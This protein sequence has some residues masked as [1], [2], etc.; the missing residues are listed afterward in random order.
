[1][2]LI[3]TLLY[4]IV[5]SFCWGTCTFLPLVRWVTCV[6]ETQPCGW[7]SFTPHVLLLCHSV[8]VCFLP[9]CCVVP[10]SLPPWWMSELL[11]VFMNNIITSNYVHTM[12][13]IL[14]TIRRWSTAVI[15]KGHWY[16]TTCYVSMYIWLYY[17]IVCHYMAFYVYIAVYMKLH[18]VCLFMYNL[19]QRIYFYIQYVRF[20]MPFYGVLWTPI[21]L[22]W[23]SLE[24]YMAFYGFLWTTYYVQTMYSYA[25]YEQSYFFTGFLCFLCL[26]IYN[27]KVKA[28][29]YACFRC[30]I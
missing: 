14:W 30:L 13:I 22:L 26:F 23:L 25:K 17:C 5:F 16:N 18:N 10:H 20:F 3:F 24:F 28:V 21:K 29:T 4:I 12:L 6:M 15:Y 1:L 8:S 7:N 19:I 27:F 2:W 11:N 9:L